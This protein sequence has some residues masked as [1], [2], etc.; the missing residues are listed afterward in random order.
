MRSA[1]PVALVN[2]PA[3]YAAHVGTVLSNH[4]MMEVI[5]PDPDAVY[6]TDDRLAGRVDR[7]GGGPG[8]GITFD[9]ERLARYTVDRPPATSLDSRYRRAPDSGISEPGIPLRGDD[10]SVTRELA[11]VGGSRARPCGG[12]RGRTGDGRAAPDHQPRLDEDLLATVDWP[13]SSCARSMRA[14]MPPSW[15]AGKS[16]VV[17]DGVAGRPSHR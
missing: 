15:S 14:A 4:L 2:S 1:C 6:T 5:D 7:P 9:E 16:I 8:L 17:S 11:E 12:G 3:R 13:P 10:R